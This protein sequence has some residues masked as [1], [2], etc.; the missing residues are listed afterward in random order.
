MDSTYSSDDD[1]LGNDEF[2]ARVKLA[3]RHRISYLETYSIC[4]PLNDGQNISYELSGLRQMV[5]HLERY[6]IHPTPSQ[7]RRIA[8][9]KRVE[10]YQLEHGHRKVSGKGQLFL[11][12][13]A[14]P[15]IS[16]RSFEVCIFFTSVNSGCSSPCLNFS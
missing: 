16:I 14:H 7:E 11:S 13:T 12:I 10:R 15:A 2:L 4:P 9:S 3:R 6:R 1:E 8:G 5:S